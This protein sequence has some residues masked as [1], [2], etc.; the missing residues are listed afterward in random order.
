M[1]IS[2]VWYGN[3]QTVESGMLTEMLVSWCWICVCCLFALYSRVCSGCLSGLVRCQGACAE[4]AVLYVEALSVGQDFCGHPTI[5][6][7][8][9]FSVPDLIENGIFNCSVFIYR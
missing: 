8:D 9:T 4:K 5:P 7:A 6:G 1:C 2:S 3:E